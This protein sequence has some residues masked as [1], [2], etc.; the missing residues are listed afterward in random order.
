LLTKS[1]KL[2]AETTKTFTHF[3]AIAPELFPEPSKPFAHL[4]AIT[5]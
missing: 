3:L 4:F 2:F 5:T 1:A